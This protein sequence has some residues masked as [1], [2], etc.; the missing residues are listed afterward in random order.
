MKITLEQINTGEDEII[1]KCNKL[2]FE[3]QK[4]LEFI[5]EP[6]KKIN[7]NKD[8]ETFLLQPMEVFYIESVDNK[9]FVYTKDTVYD[10][11]HPLNFYEINFSET[12]LVR[13]GKS[14]L[15]NLHHIRKLKSIVN[16]RIEIIL[17][18]DERLIVS[19]HYSTVFKDRLGI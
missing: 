19:R 3:I 18:T 2:T 16:S 10:S 4:I 13:I 15:V 8:G 6:I 1:I 14:S 11:L 5:K 7:V 17:E 12:G 9:T